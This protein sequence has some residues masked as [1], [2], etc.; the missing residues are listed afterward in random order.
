MSESHRPG[1]GRPEPSPNWFQRMRA[2]L[3]PPPPV[4]TLL[5]AVIRSVDIDDGHLRVDYLAQPSFANPAGSVQGGMLC[6]ML[7]DL[8]ASLVD[9]TLA[10]GQFVATLTLNTSYLRSAGIGPLQGHARLK[11]RGRQICVVEADLLQNGETVASAVATCMIAAAA[12][13]KG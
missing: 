10:P 2:G 6:A 11:R 8:C 12:P 9:A 5:G 7:D 3:E 13:T 4:A 1:Q